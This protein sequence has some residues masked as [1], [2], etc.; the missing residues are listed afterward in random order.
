MS[1]ETNNIKNTSKVI[2]KAA[3]H[4]VYYPDDLPTVYSNSAYFTMSEKDLTIDF[5]LRH[6]EIAEDYSVPPPTE[7]KTRI[8][9]SLHH[10]KQLTIKLSELINNFEE[11]FGEIIIE[12][13][14]K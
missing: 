8:L 4:E 6:P 7:I 13:A 9:I 1:S 10:A 11:N 2:S 12:P 3:G 5:G 14:K